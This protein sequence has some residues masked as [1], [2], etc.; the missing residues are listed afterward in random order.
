MCS[1]QKARVVALL[2]KKVGETEQPVLKESKKLKAWTSKF[3]DGF[4]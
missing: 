4:N 2:D 1:R 3:D